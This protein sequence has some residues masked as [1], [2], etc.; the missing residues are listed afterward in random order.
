MSIESFMK[1]EYLIVSKFKALEAYYMARDCSYADKE[2]MQTVILDSA[3]KYL[4]KYGKLTEIDQK[5]FL[6]ASNIA[7]A[8]CHFAMY[9]KFDKLNLKALHDVVAQMNVQKYIDEF[10]QNVKQPKNK[11]TEQENNK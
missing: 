4:K 3:K 6:K 11:K 2:T 8:A 5:I 9:I 1:R 10:N 7:E